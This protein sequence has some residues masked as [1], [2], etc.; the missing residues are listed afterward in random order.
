MYQDSDSLSR[1]LFFSIN[2]RLLPAYSLWIDCSLT[3]RLW[4]VYGLH[5]SWTSNM[6]VVT[7][8]L[9]TKTVEW[10]KNS[11]TSYHQE[12]IEFSLTKNSSIMDF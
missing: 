2:W 11:V 7:D 1:F 10:S 5:G 4:I 6:D 8:I 9:F 12:I 3:C